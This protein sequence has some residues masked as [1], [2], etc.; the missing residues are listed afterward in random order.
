MKKNSQNLAQ[1]RL[2]IQDDTG[3]VLNSVLTKTEQEKSDYLDL[4][5]AKNKKPRIN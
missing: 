4:I 5:I 1:D 3:I 2:T